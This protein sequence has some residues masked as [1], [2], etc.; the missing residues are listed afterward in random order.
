M[1]L[2]RAIN[3]LSCGLLFSSKNT[4]SNTRAGASLTSSTQ[5]NPPLFN[6]KGKTNAQLAGLFINSRELT[7][8]NL[9][10]FA[11]ALA[12]NIK[13]DVTNQNTVSQQMTSLVA[14]L[15]TEYEAQTHNKTTSFKLAQTSSVDSLLHDV[16]EMAHETTRLQKL[17]GYI[18]R[19]ANKLFKFG[20]VGGS[21]AGAIAVGTA[22][23]VVNPLLVP[24][25]ALSGAIF[26]FASSFLAT[27]GLM[28]VSNLT[29]MAVR[30]K[31]TEQTQKTT[32]Q[33]FETNFRKVIQ[34][35][36]NEAMRAKHQLQNQALQAQHNATAPDMLPV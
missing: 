4:D 34:D 2:S 19:N 29:R 21:V 25:G 5:G 16:A 36:E 13:A 14:N 27:L 28:A 26:G 9:N 33:A 11:S 10:Q 3:I 24:I 20:L 30:E 18:D 6:L 1:K 31:T 35:L 15:K 17:T 12:K 23:G 7:P 22:A 8:Q 32:K